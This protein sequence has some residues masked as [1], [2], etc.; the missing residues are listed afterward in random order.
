MMNAIND[1][2]VE[3]AIKDPDRMYKT[4]QEVLGDCHLCDEEKEAILNSW[5]QDQIALLRAEEESMLSDQKASGAA[6][7]IQDIEKAKKRL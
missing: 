6:A 2:I 4:P 7:L 3:E 1:L 5:Q